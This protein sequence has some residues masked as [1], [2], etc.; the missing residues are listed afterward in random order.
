MDYL[1]RHHT[2]SI[3][4]VTPLSEVVDRGKLNKGREDKGIADSN[5]PV[6]SCGISHFRERV[7]GTDTE[8]GHGQHSG[9]SCRKRHIEDG[10]VKQY[11]MT[12][13]LYVVNIKHK[14]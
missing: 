14:N 8:S 1:L 10:H 7:P 2:F 4:S 11:S 13:F 3:P 12:H 5:K 6:H 9:H